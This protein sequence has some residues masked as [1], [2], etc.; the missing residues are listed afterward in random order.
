MN[1]RPFRDVTRAE[2]AE[3]LPELVAD[4]SCSA[5]N[6][7]QEPERSVCERTEPARATGACAEGRAAL[8]SQARA[9]PVCGVVLLVSLLWLWLWCLWGVGVWVAVLGQG[10]PPPL[11]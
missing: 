3:Q 10:R 9:T 8:R 11:D 5:A 1:L 7:H 4:S 6:G 2:P